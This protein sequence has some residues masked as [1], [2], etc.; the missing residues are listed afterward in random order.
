MRL[1]Y[2]Q[3]RFP[4]CAQSS[5]ETGHSSK[6]PE[7]SEALGIEHLV[8]LSRAK[9]KRVVLHYEVLLLPTVRVQGMGVVHNLG[10]V[11]AGLAR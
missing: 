1:V 7:S 4:I 9:G 11:D 5:F 10:V 2:A 3:A 8:Q 6:L